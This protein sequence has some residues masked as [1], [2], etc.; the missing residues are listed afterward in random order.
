MLT[1]GRQN[2][3]TIIQGNALDS[4]N[5]AL[6]DNL[7]RLRD[8]R[9]GRIVNTQTTNHSGLFAFR[10]VDPGSYVVELM[11]KDTLVVATS[12]IMSVGVGEAI[13]TVVKLP[14]RV[15]VFAGLLGQVTEAA[16]SKSVVAAAASS[17]I[18]TTKATGVPVTPE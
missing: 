11:G 18:L 3:L 7:V 4:S 17:G 9:I 12:Q 5:G 15:P 14:F 1:R 16:A 2:V 10:G 8:A 6:P 13:S